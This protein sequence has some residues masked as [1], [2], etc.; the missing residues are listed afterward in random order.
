MTF[1]IDAPRVAVAGQTETFPIRR[2]Y[3]I[4]LNYADHVREMGGEPDRSAFPCI[5]TKF[6]DTYSPSG[7]PVAYPPRTADFHHEIELVIAIG[8]EGADIE[9]GGAK[10]VIYGY[11]AGIDFTRRDL[12][13]AMKDKGWPWDIGKNF[14]QAMPMGPIGRAEDVGH[15][16]AGAVWLEINGDRRQSSDLSEMIWSVDAIVAE[17]SSYARLRPGDLIMTGTPSGVGPVKPGDAV[18]GGIEGLA[19][20]ETVITAAHT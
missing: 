5:F 19:P 13:F 10:D 11:A 20:V 7:A 15:P 9:P 2:I 3:C 14:D 16:R 17:V 18:K 6:A 4:G 8:G 1:S 12:Q